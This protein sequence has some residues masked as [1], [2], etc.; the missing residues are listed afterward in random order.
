MTTRDAIGDSGF[1]GRVFYGADIPT[2]PK[3]GDLWV[4]TD[5]NYLNEIERWCWTDAFNPPIWQSADIKLW[6]RDYAGNYSVD[7]YL[8]I[9]NIWTGYDLFL[10]NCNFVATYTNQQSST[11]YWTISLR[12]ID[13]YYGGNLINQYQ[14]QT[15]Q[16]NVW[17]KQYVSPNQIYKSSQYACINLKLVP[18]GNPGYINLAYSLGYR[19]IKN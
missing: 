12:T 14:N 16:A 8:P 10:S 5:L 17:Q 11:N 19:L 18:T 4:E 13:F 7:F 15:A 3:K 1:K 2:N 6:N 9:A